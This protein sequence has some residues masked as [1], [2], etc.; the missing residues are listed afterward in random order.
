[1]KRKS[2]I[3]A[4]N[5]VDEIGPTVMRLSDAGIHGSEGVFEY[6]C[7]YRINPI[8]YTSHHRTD[9]RALKWGSD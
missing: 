8:L 6:Y 7:E 1:M 2:P 4:S 3:L 9:L 5:F